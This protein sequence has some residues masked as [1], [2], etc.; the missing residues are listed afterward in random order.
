MLIPPKLVGTV[1]A[2]SVKAV[3]AGSTSLPS[4]LISI[5][6]NEIPL[7]MSTFT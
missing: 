7:E 3:P 4:T 2:E 5:V 6:A 1:P